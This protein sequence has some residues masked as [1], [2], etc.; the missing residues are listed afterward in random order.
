MIHRDST[1]PPRDCS[2]FVENET[3]AVCYDSKWGRAVEGR[4]VSVGPKGK[5]NVPE[6]IK[7]RFMPWAN[8]EAGFVEMFCEPE[9]H[10]GHPHYGGWIR[11]EGELG[12]LRNLG[13][14][15]DWYSILKTETITSGGYEVEPYE[16]TPKE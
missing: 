8:E 12:I 13:C 6:W 15:G 7:V 4:V 10:K 9:F 14:E 3:V 11:G 16:R 5:T 1:T 2:M